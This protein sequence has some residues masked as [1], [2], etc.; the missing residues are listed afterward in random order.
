MCAYNV[1]IL[2]LNSVYGNQCEMSEA[3]NTIKTTCPRDCYDGC[4]I[5]VVMRDGEISR[6]AGNPDHPSNRGPLCGKCS[7][8]Y[9]GV[10]RDENARLLHPMR[11]TG[12]KGAGE[13][14]RI[15]W[16]EALKE[17]ASRLGTIVSD[18]GPRSVHHTHYTGTCSKI[19]GDF[20]GRFFDHLGA[21]EIDPDTV[22]NKAGHVA[23]GY[24]F[25]NSAN[26]F[27]PR[28][29]K[30]SN[31]IL[32]WG[33]NP[34]HSAPH[35]DRYWLSENDAKVIVID[36]V[37]HE[38]AVKADLHLQLRPGSD[39]ALAF[40]MVHVMQRDGLLDMAYISDHVLGYDELAETIAECTPQWGEEKTGVPATLIEEAAKIYGAG[41]S[42]L[43]MGQG[44]Q[45]QKAG[46]NIFRAC[47]MLPAFSGN[48]G[49]PGA[50]AYYLNSSLGISARRGA[51]PKFVA[52]GDEAPTLSQ[53]D[54]PAAL[55]D[56]ETIRAY[57]VWNCNPIASNPAQTEMRRGLSREDLFTVVVD[58]FMTDTAKYADIVL[59]AASF[60]EFDDLCSS[61]FH[62]IAGPQVKC[63][64]PVGEALP[65][66]EIFRRL[67]R[68]MD[69][70]APELYE[71]DQTM[72]DAL[73]ENSNVGLTWEELKEKGWNHLS[74]Q[75]MVLWQDGAF[76]TPSGK[77]EIASAQAK[78]D[79]FSLAPTPDADLAPKGGALRLLS[80]ADKHLMNS[81]YGND[82]RVH[83]L[84]GPASVSIHPED[85]KAH[86]IADGDAI[87]LSND[88]GELPLTARV[89]DIIP[90]G[91]LLAYKSRWPGCETS[92]ANVN[93]LHIPQKSDM[94]ESTSVHSTEVLMKKA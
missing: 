77:I 15:S 67:A 5:S 22:C 48:M 66:Q 35:V 6:V 44:V 16:D 87:V 53:M 20:P 81:S 25:G 58:C 60:L 90:R 49:K 37:R 80:P 55:Q 34:S 69:M 92:D 75:P 42:L 61:Y 78:A 51:S 62:M 86:G 7:V 64:E 93:L 39:A 73:L 28:T 54:V 43:W 76:A 11:R 79:G 21:T 47:A 82:A 18:H 70:D 85:A 91:T 31:C 65:N 23:W 14:T 56:N 36:P 3:K 88:G 50:G 1:R 30:D 89:E 63:T 68:A 9:N 46:G 32:V 83:D 40:A 8:A 12:A 94:G 26:G 57:F 52:G 4:G 74:D 45:R 27:D 2:R 84:M 71:D 10:W 19:A 41:P 72:I 24:V 59:P 13:F 29:A 33:A 38:T 17:I